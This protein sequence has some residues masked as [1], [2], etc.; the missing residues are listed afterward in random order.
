M[1]LTPSRKKLVAEVFSY[2]SKTLGYEKILYKLIE[3][4]YD[5]S[6]NSLKKS[7]GLFI[8]LVAEKSRGII[9]TL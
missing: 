7:R 6:R 8:N 5:F 3:I 9:V 2:Y 4:L 1:I